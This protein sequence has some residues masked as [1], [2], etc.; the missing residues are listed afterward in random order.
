MQVNQL[1]TESRGKLGLGLEPPVSRGEVSQRYRHLAKKLHPDANG[2]DKRAEERL[3]S[4]NHAYA[5]LR[6]IGRLG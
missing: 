1:H 5:T 6:N 4:V 2:G 3:K